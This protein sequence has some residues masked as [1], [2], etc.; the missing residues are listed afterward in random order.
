MPISLLKQRLY[1]LTLTQ[2]SID[3]FKRLAKKYDA[4]YQAMIRRLVDY[5]AINQ[6]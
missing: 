3:A 2:K 5:Y 6:L 1:V 4:S